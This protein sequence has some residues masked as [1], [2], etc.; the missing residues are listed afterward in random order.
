MTK[1]R[2]LGIFLIFIPMTLISVYTIATSVL[3]F[4]FIRSLIAI[5]IFGLACCLVAGLYLVLNGGND[6]EKA[7]NK[8]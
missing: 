3:T 4:G 2:K 8:K 1:E 5:I 7:G 6:V